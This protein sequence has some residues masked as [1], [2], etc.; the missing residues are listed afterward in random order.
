MR[1]F[2][3]CLPSITPGQWSSLKY[4]SKSLI[5]NENKT[6]LKDVHAQKFPRTGFF[7]TLTAGR[8]DKIRLKT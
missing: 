7:R 4:C 6:G 8:N 1:Q 5:N 3:E 2:R